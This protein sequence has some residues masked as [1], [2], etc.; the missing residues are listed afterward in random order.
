M[1][2]TRDEFAVRAMQAFIVADAVENHQIG[3]TDNFS[4]S[5]VAD[6]AYE[7]ADE[8]LAARVRNRPQ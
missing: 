4:A 5:S 8:M 6:R 3:E 1:Q 7:M 2:G